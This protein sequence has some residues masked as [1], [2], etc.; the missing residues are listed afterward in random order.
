MPAE[1]KTSQGTEVCL[2]CECVIPK[3]EEC[4]HWDDKE[5]PMCKLC[6]N[7]LLFNVATREDQEQE[8]LRII[9]EVLQNATS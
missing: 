4:I 8:E 1:L 6:V 3:L 5:D 7:T 9:E 2:L